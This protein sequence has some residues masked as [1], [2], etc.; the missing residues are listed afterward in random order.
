[1]RWTRKTR[2]RNLTKIISKKHAILKLKTD[3]QFCW[4]ILQVLTRWS[5]NCV[6]L[7]YLKCKQAFQRTKDLSIFLIQWIS[8][9]AK[10]SCY[11]IHD[12]HCIVI[13]IKDKIRIT[14]INKLYNPNLCSKQETVI[15]DKIR[16]TFINTLKRSFTQRKI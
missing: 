13:I 15:K 12:T 7:S 2:S 8:Q 11:H 16:I 9:N 6:P 14:F 3:L 5:V 4:N 10:K 1:M